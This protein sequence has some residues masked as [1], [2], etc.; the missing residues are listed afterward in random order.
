MGSLDT[1]VELFERT[2]DAE[3]NEDGAASFA[4]FEAMLET[5]P[6]VDMSSAFV[7]LAMALERKKKTE[8]LALVAYKRVL[9]LLEDK[10]RK[11]KQRSVV[12]GIWW[13]KCVVYQQMGKALS[14]AP[15]PGKLRDAVK[16]CEEM[17]DIVPEEA[18][19]NF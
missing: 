7:L 9:M 3:G 16:I 11:E 15:E 12:N 17:I 5:Q 14:Y 6:D 18:V 2:L 4:Q 1:L 8:H 19:L 10:L 13:E